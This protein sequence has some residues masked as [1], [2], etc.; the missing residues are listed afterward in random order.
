MF[1]R[2]YFAGAYF[3]PAYFPPM[4][5][6]VEVEYPARVGG[7][8]YWDYDYEPVDRKVWLAADED[9]EIVDLI[10]LFVAVIEGER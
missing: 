9:E 6:L 5:A 1:A 8:G 2:N 10:P 3:A 7:G 4:T